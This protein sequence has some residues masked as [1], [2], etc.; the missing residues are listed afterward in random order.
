MA[1]TVRDSAVAVERG[2]KGQARKL[3]QEEGIC[4]S[5]LMNILVAVCSGIR[6]LKV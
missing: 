3:A 6:N 1:Q 5:K 2:R 4:T